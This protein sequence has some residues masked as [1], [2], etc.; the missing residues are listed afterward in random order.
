MDRVKDYWNENLHDLA[1]ARHPIGTAGFFDDLWEYHFDKQRHL[2]KVL[3]YAEYDGKD[4]L[5]LGCGVGTDAAK[6]ASYGA[7]VT[8]VDISERAIGLAKDN[9]GFKGLEGTF[10]VM[11]GNAMEFD[12]N[13][14][15]VIYAHGI[16]PYTHD[17]NGMAREIFRV[18][19]PGGKAILQTYNR[20]SWMYLLWKTM[21]VRLEHQVAPSFHIHTVEEMKEMTRPFSKVEIITERFP[22]RTRL[23]TGVRGAMYNAV[24]VGDRKSVV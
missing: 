20:D 9:F 18:L 5:D 2:E 24:F 23:H 22:V 15:D 16:L 3:N 6:F 10:L 17:Y 13:S 12:D 19:K 1:I 8:G 21:K 7:K 14:F 11:D 4:L